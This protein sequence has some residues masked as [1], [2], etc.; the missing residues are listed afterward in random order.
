VPPAVVVAVVHW[1]AVLALF[2]HGGTSY[3]IELKEQTL[4]GWYL[5]GV[6]AVAAGVGCLHLEELARRLRAWRRRLALCEM[7]ETSIN[8]ATGRVVV[9]FDGAQ[10]LNEFRQLR[11]TKKGIVRLPLL[12]PGPGGS[13]GRDHSKDRQQIE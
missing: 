1:P 9:L 3:A 8:R 4:P 6:V 12:G 2:G 13:D 5:A 10:V 11:L 7:R